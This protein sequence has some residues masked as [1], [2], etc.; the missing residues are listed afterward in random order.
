[1]YAVA[2]PLWIDPLY[3][4]QPTIALLGGILLLISGG[5]IAISVITKRLE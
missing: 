2:T 5:W 4:Y 1:M 3:I